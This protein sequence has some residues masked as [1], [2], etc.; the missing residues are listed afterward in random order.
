MRKRSAIPWSDATTSRT[1]TTC[2][3]DRAAH[4]RHRRLDDVV[5]EDVGRIADE[6]RLDRILTEPLD[7]G[8]PR[9]V[10]VG[11]APLRLVRIAGDEMD[12]ASLDAA[13]TPSASRQRRRAQ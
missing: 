12:H 6:E 4:L 7:E 11:C 2:G 13:A 3:R 10:E 5:A 1:A 8:V 9:V